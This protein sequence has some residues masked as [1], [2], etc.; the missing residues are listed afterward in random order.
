VRGFTQLLVSTL[1]AR[2]AT[3][4]FSVLLVLFGV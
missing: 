4:M 1:A 2:I 3:Q